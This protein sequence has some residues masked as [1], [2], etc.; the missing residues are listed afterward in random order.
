MYMS[1]PSYEVV[2]EKVELN[3][4]NLSDEFL[5]DLKTSSPSERVLKS[6]NM[7]AKEFKQTVIKLYFGEFKGLKEI[8]MIIG[9][10][11]R[12]FNKLFKELGV[13]YPLGSKAGKVWKHIRGEYNKPI[14][15]RIKDQ[16]I[17]ELLGGSN[18][19]V[20]TK[21]SPFTNNL[22]IDE[23]VTDLKTL[24]KISI[25]ANKF[26]DISIVDLYK[27]NEIV[28]KFE[29]L[30]TANLRFHKSIKEKEWIKILWD[31]LN[32]KYG[33]F[34]D[35]KKRTKSNIDS[36]LKWTCAYDT[37]SS[38]QFL[39]IWQEWYQNNQGKLQKTLP[40]SLKSLTPNILLHWYVNDGGFDNTAISIY[41]LNFKQIDILRMVDMLTDI[42]IKAKMNEKRGRILISVSSKKNNRIRFFEYLS[43]ADLYREAIKVV[44]HKFI[45]GVKLLDEME[46]LK[47]DHPEYFKIGRKPTWD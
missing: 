26:N 3:Y 43:K 47:I 42:G 30:N 22:T 33:G 2:S 24:E 18:V 11:Q 36:R 6:K 14:S 19:R 35:I 4:K 40:E 46:K 7:T 45:D 37:G 15:S 29:F 16:I 21:E 31:Q 27:W 20:Q 23:Y 5:S 8:G 34:R 25:K 9:S 38:Y 44:P 10:D 1:N 13:Y 28:S 41:N 39:K 17:G 32:S 12:S